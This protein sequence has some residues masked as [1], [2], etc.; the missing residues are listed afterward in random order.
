MTNPSRRTFVQIAGA[1]LAGG[2]LLPGVRADDADRPAAARAIRKAV[3]FDMI[4][5]GATTVEKFQI[6]RDLG[7]DGVEVSRPSVLPVEE[8][9][10][11]RDIAGIPIHGVVNSAHWAQ[12]LSHPD[13][14]VRA[15]GR[16]AL[17][18]ALRDAQ[19]LGASSVLLV[20]AI[21]NKLVS[22]QEA[23]TR[24]QAEI[25]QVLPLAEELGVR[26]ALENVWNNF[27]LSPLEAARYV[28][29]FENSWIGWHFD[30]GNI[31]LY[32]WP[33]QWIRT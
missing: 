3:K 13:E 17:E 5:D 6:L 18:T 27:L 16:R 15:H 9:L 31:V 22:Y 28:D 24:S 33:E 30:V 29:A 20:P 7:Y 26:I 23:W 21:V 12:P 1:T 2:A 8:L 32:G 25:R 4:A 19:T 10:R 14:A 11:A